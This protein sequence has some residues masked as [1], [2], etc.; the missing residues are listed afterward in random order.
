MKKIIMIFAVSMFFIT[1]CGSDSN[2]GKTS[3]PRKE[4]KEEIHSIIE[5][6]EKEVY[7]V[8]PENINQS[9]AKLLA[10]YYVKY[11]AFKDSLAP[12]YLYKAA[13]IYMNTGEPRK[14]ID[15]LNEIIK[16][17]PSFDKIENCYFLRA[18][19]YD[20]KMKDFK[21]AQKYYTEYIDKYPKGDF[22]NDAKL[23]RENL[24]KSTEQMFEEI[25]KK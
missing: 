17:Y 20:D 13:G 24:G 25:E 4:T 6:T 1:S 8:A 2:K 3:E 14:S 19:V 16:D 21:N 11:A 18:Y 9:K 5:S 7:G 10:M 22:S 12:E 15:A 23:L